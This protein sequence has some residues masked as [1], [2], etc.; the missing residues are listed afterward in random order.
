MN[1]FLALQSSRVLQ[2]H[3]QEVCGLKW[4]PDGQSLASGGNDNKLF[5]WSMVCF[6]FLIGTFF[7]HFCEGSIYS[8]CASNLVARKITLCTLM[9]YEMKGKCGVRYLTLGFYYIQ[10]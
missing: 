8:Y 7:F 5:V 1:I 2:G 3:R 10:T 9:L 4:S 6:K